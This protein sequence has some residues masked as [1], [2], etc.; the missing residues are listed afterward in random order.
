VPH[1]TVVLD[2]GHG[3]VDTGAISKS[4][5]NE[6]DIN[7]A[8]V[9]KLGNMLSSIGIRTIYTRT[10]QDALYNNFSHG[11][12]LKDMKKRIE[13]INQANPN[14][15]VSIHLNSFNDSTA[16]GAQV[17]YK[18]KDDYSAELA[19]CLQELFVDNIPGSRSNS[20]EG[21]FYILNNSPS[22]AILVECGFLSNPE[23]EKKL[24]TDS[25]QEKIAYYIM[26]G[27]V[28]FWA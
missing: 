6:R 8:I 7:L 13:L 24:K 26:C 21:D 9:Q 25:Y 3:G 1:F 17:F 23:E 20:K 5:T 19:E 28:S 12:K 4:G 22:A 10:T 18:P 2:A 15:V 16:H 11:H 14:L 27:I